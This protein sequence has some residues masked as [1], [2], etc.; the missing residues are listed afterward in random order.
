MKKYL[1]PKSGNF[2]KANLHCHTVYSDGA[3]TPQQV[4]DIYKSL[5]YSIVA[6]TDH[7]LLIAHDELCDDTFLP[8]HGFEMEINDDA[9]DFLYAKSCHICFIAL[10]PDNL[11]QPC[12][13]KELY[14][15]GNAPKY[16]DL[17]QYD[18]SEPDFIREHSHKCITEIMNTARNKGF[19]VTY[20]HPTWSLENYSD[21]TGYSGMHAMEIFNGA[22]LAEGFEDYNPRVYDDLLRAGRRIYCIGADDNHNYAPKGSRKFDSGLAFTVIKAENLEYRTVTK[23]LEEGNFYASQGPEIYE[24][25]QEGGKVYIKCSPADRIIC[26][27][28]VRASGAVYG[29]NGQPVTG[30]EF[31]IK[32]E[33]GYFRITVIDKSGKHACTNAYFIEDIKE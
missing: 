12:W 32:P 5:G 13:H 7:D 25:W 10:N 16:R 24:L 8:L 31:D 15:F 23:A 14:L 6:F 9:P 21:Y 1:L 18:K 28:G 27:Y 29:E 30:A 17:I 22:S 4:K 11:I 20:N 3:K 19:F 33:F 2:Y 26:N